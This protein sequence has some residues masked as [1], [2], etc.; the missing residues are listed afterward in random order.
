MKQSGCGAGEDWEVGSGGDRE[1]TVAAGR[2]MRSR[3]PRGESWRGS[4]AGR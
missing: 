1:V 4:G 3:G 2:K